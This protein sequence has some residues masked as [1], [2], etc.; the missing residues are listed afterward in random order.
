MTVCDLCGKVAACIKTD[1]GGQELNVCEDCPVMSFTSEQIQIASA[2]DSRVQALSGTGC[3]D[4]TIMREMLNCDM[5]GFER[6]WSTSQRAEIDELCR[7]L[8][9]FHFFAKIEI[10]GSRN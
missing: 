7:R 8:P 2:I 9:W 1:I 10:L 6:L 5:P 3:D 4:A